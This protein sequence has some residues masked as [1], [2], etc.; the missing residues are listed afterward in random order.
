[1]KLKKL[2]VLFLT[3]SMIATGLTGCGDDSKDDKDSKTES[4][5]KDDKDEDKADDKDSKD[6]NEKSDP[7]ALLEKALTIKELSNGELELT[8]D[9][10]IPAIMATLDV[11]YSAQFTQVAQYMKGD[12]TG[13]FMGQSMDKSIKSYV[14]SSDDKNSIT[15]TYDAENDAWTKSTSQ[16]LEETVENTIGDSKPTDFFNNITFVEEK[17]GNKIITAEVAIDKIMEKAND[18]SENSS[19][20]EQ[21]EQAQAY[22][23]ILKNMDNKMVITFSI[24]SEKETL[25]GVS[26][27]LSTYLDEAIKKLM[28]QASEESEGQ[29]F[30]GNK[31][32]LSFTLK[33]VGDTSVEIPSDI[34]ENATEADDSDMLDFGSISDSDSDKDDDTEDASEDDAE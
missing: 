11:T 22:V 13:S 26:V 3:G 10:D 9:I 14:D 23:D 1:M 8:A 5:K 2:A 33:N 19:L 29:D 21:I 4:T 25:S 12:L 24:D 32:I 27:D 6:D 18:S 28:E 34:I 7:K 30:S 20:S 31:C 17:D 16:L 15:Y